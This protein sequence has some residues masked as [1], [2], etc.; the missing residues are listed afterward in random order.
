MLI[1]EG[2]SFFTRSG[3][4]VALI[5]S[6]LRGKSLL[7]VKLEII[8][9]IC[10]LVCKVCIEYARFQNSVASQPMLD[11]ETNLRLHRRLLVVLLM[12]PMGSATLILQKETPLH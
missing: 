3:F 8:V 5:C 4:F 10:H 2:P 6:W 1:A 9:R 7:L 11:L 12:Q